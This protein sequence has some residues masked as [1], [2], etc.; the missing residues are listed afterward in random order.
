[1]H[2]MI[3]S[4]TQTNKAP[5]SLVRKHHETHFADRGNILISQRYQLHLNSALIRCLKTKMMHTTKKNKEEKKKK[6][7]NCGDQTHA[8][9]TL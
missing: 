8:T 6:R 1:M 9:A 3:I 5:T 4:L 7:H 2:N